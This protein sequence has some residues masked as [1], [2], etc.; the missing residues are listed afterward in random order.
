[1]V[2]AKRR[3]PYVVWMLAKSGVA[4]ATGP[5]AMG[6]MCFITPN[7]S[8]L[9]LGSLSLP[10]QLA[11]FIAMEEGSPLWEG[12]TPIRL[13]SS[14]GVRGVYTDEDLLTRLAELRDKNYASQAALA[15]M[16]PV[17]FRE[18]NPYRIML[19]NGEF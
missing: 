13:V 12:A 2:K 17:E 3:E 19:E 16:T 9:V 11:G 15:G 6:M 7:T 5:E 14:E 8:N 4:R 10:R 18:R 1:L